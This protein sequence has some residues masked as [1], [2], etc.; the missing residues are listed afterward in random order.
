MKT[1]TIILLILT[2]VLLYSCKCK[3]DA[4]KLNSEEQGWQPYS[5]GDVL[6]FVSDST[7]DS[8]VYKVTSIV[9]DE[10]EITGCVEPKG[11]TDYYI[12]FTLVKKPDYLEIANNTYYDVFLDYSG[13]L[14][15]R[16]ISFKF[17]GYDPFIKSEGIEING[18]FYKDIAIRDY[19]IIIPGYGIAKN[20]GVIYIQFLK[21][22][23]FNLIT[24]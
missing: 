23:I 4:P 15:S 16:I 22:E 13:A 6:I 5:V 18:K 14:D 12:Y 20:Y 2:A 24:N 21:G 17:L 11:H 19:T 10:Q 3:K 1:R 7:G 9:E 8:L